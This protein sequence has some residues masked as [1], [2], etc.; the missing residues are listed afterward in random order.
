MIDLAYLDEDLLTQQVLGTEPVKNFRYVEGGKLERWNG[1]S[2]VLYDL[3]VLYPFVRKALLDIL[4]GRLCRLTTLDS[5]HVKV[6][7]ELMRR[8]GPLRSV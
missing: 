2:W 3:G 1:A 6:R 7:N 5:V 4:D 8:A